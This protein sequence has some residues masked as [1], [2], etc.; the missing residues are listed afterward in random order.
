MAM[1]TVEAMHIYCRLETNAYVKI[2]QIDS[3]QIHIWR[4][5]QMQACGQ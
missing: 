5:S 1:T 2:L 3:N 4:G